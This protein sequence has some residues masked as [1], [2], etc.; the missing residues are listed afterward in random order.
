[1][2]AAGGVPESDISLGCGGDGGASGDVDLDSLGECRRSERASSARSVW[3]S[4][5]DVDLV[6]AMLPAQAEAFVRALGKDWY[7]D[8]QT[9]RDS[10]AAGRSFNVIH[11]RNVMKVDVFPARDPFHRTQLARAT[12]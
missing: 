11:M 5:M 3:R 9:V 7:A 10:I 8:V 1:M 12:V 4:T 6:A 2:A